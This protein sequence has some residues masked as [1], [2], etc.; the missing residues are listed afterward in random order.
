MTYDDVIYKLKNLAYLGNKDDKDNEKTIEFA[1]QMAEGLE[2]AHKMYDENFAKN[3]LN[4][5]AFLC[6][7]NIIECRIEGLTV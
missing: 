7:L 3:T 5:E 1:I 6:C 4:A 2:A